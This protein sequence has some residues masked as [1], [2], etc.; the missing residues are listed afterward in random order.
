[1]EPLNAIPA[2]IVKRG[3]GRLQE[4]CA[5]M[6][7]HCCRLDGVMLLLAF[8][9]FICTLILSCLIGMLIGMIVTVIL[10]K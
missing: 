5:F 7:K 3:G 1:M 10:E 6:K 9:I 2:S 8:A 4:V